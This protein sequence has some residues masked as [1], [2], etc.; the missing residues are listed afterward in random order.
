MLQFAFIFF[1]PVPFPPAAYASH[2][3]QL[4]HTIQLVLCAQAS[5]RVSFRFSNFPLWQAEIER[6]EGEL[7]GSSALERIYKATIEEKDAEIKAKSRRVEE[8]QS[9][10]LSLKEKLV[11]AGGKP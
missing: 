1:L 8:L 5:L 4:T 7:Q 11:K 2:T 3:I 9:E 10:N 6:L